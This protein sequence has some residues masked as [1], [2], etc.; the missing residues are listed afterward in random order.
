MLKSTLSVAF[1]W[2]KMVLAIIFWF[3]VDH[4]FHYYVLWWPCKII[5]ADCKKSA[6]KL[7]AQA[8]NLKHKFY[9]YSWYIVRDHILHDYTISLSYR[10]NIPH[11]IHLIIYLTWVIYR[12][13]Y[14]FSWSWKQL[15]SVSLM[16]LWKR[17][18][19]G[20]SFFSLIFSYFIF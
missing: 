1:R 3:K 16:D 12:E 19:D 17:G 18:I 5:P 10:G 6:Y 2:L 15:Y 20:F 13:I 11:H 8:Y 4:C 7:Q 14:H 9:T